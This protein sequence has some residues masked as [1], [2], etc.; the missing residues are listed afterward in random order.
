MAETEKRS[1]WSRFLR[2]LR[3]VVLADGA[4][5]AWSS[6]AGGR[7]D[8]RLV[9]RERPRALGVARNGIEANFPRT[10]TAGAA[11]G[12]GGDGAGGTSGDGVVTGLVIWTTPFMIGVTGAGLVLCVK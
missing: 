7:R 2:K 11:C 5:Q 3:S 9:R 8:V 10:A 6:A 12:A 4:E 1:L